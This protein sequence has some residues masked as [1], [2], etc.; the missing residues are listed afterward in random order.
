M[1]VGAKGQSRGSLWGMLKLGAWRGW[2]YVRGT[3]QVLQTL[4][5]TQALLWK[6]IFPWS[7]CVVP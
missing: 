5:V 7:P 2:L 3:A 6:D 1:R 4:G